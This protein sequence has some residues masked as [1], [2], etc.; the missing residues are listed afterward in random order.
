MDLFS[1]QPVFQTNI[2][3]GYLHKIQPK[4]DRRVETIKDH[5]WTWSRGCNFDVLYPVGCKYEQACT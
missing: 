4:S 1:M 5:L 2:L 3:V